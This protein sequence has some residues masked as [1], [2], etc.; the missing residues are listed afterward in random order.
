M[1]S[2]R[3]S[4]IYSFTLSLHMFTDVKKNGIRS[5]GW[6][7]TINNYDQAKTD[8]VLGLVADYVVCGKE[9][10]EDKKTPHLQGYVYWKTQ[11]TFNSVQKLLVGAHLTA[12]KGTGSQN[13]DYCIKEGDVLL[14]LGECPKDP[15]QGAK[16]AKNI[17]TM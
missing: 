5:R 2:R 14:E 8:S 4:K 9:V 13:R 6:C 17:G 10:G 3:A 16:K 7:F 15:A 11:K 1:R 12:A